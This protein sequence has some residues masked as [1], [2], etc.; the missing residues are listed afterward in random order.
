MHNF[1][2]ESDAAMFQLQLT[3]F[4]RNLLLLGG[5]VMIARCG[6]GSLSLDALMARRV[7]TA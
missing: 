1:W 7:E 3:L 4:I 5:A 6:A 2:A